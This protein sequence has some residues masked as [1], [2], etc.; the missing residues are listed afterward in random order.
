MSK[1]S[2]LR[3]LSVVL[4]LKDAYEPEASPTIT[5]GPTISQFL[6]TSKDNFLKAVTAKTANEWTVVMGNEAG[7]TCVISTSP[8]STS[9]TTLP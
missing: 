1:R 3:R 5:D 2:P 9:P 6:S 4:R 8:V 7:G